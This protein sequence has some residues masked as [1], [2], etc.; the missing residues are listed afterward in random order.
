MANPR[1]QN[2]GDTLTIETR[3]E[4]ALIQHASYCQT[5]SCTFPNC[6]KVRKL[7]RHKEDCMV[8]FEGG[9]SECIQVWDL[10]KLHAKHCKLP[11]H[12]C[13]VHCC[14]ALKE[15]RARETILLRIDEIEKIL[16]RT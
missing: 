13:Q 7:I 6:L 14:R 4:I 16:F 9:C 3:R 5:L 2:F 1:V 12:E 15:V 10:L 11:D 8:G